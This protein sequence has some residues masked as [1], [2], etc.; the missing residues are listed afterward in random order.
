[1][2]SK[3]SFVGGRSGS[4]R[5]R[6]ADAGTKKVMKKSVGNMSFRLMT[7]RLNNSGTTVF[8]NFS[9]LYYSILKALKKTLL[10]SNYIEYR[11]VIEKFQKSI[12]DS[13]ANNRR[14]GSDTQTYR[15]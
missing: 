2:T 13:C 15:Q 4:E 10:V 3:F 1:M 14:S 7:Q 5:G 6:K 9:T 8:C 12:E 11:A